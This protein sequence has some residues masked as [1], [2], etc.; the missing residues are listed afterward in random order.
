LYAATALAL[1]DGDRSIRELEAEI[2]RDPD[3]DGELTLH[4]A[5]LFRDRGRFS[6]CVELIEPWLERQGPVGDRARHLAIRAW[7]DEARTT[8]DA[9]R[10]LARGPELAARIEDRTLQQQVS[11][12]LG[13]AYAR[14]G[15]PLRAADAYRGVLR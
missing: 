12:M 13:D 8:G 9:E 1:G 5:E 6:R 2:R 15:E 11:A 3:D 4:L 14:L 7:V 10:L